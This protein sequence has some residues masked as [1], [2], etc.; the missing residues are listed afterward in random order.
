M[1]DFN[2]LFILGFDINYRELLD[3]INVVDFIYWC[4][5]LILQSRLD[6]CRFNAS[7]CLTG[8]SGDFVWYDPYTSAYFDS[9]TARDLSHTYNPYDDNFPTGYVLIS[10]YNSSRRCASRPVA[11]VVAPVFPEEP[12][13]PAVCPFIVTDSK[14]DIAAVFTLI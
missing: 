9:H 6:I 1:R 13:L 2:L 4:E 7:A 10:D 5:V 8:T 11:V 12:M 14:H 3:L